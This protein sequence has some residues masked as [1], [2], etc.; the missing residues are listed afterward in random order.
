MTINEITKSIISIVSEYLES[1]GTGSDI[2]VK[3]VLFGKNAVLDSMGLV[4]I[5]IDLESHFLD[6]DIEISLTSESA[7]SRK[8]SPF[9]TIATLA[10]FINEQI[11]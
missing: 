6:N 2:D 4:N 5:V 1:Q 8:Q 3:T 9:R 11:K 10:E 7:M